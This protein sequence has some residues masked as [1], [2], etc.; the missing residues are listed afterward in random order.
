MGWVEG[1]MRLAGPWRVQAGP[2]TISEVFWP[3]VLLPGLTFAVLY[4]WPFLDQWWTRDRAAHHVLERPR[5][6]PKRTALGVGVL[7]FYVVLFVAGSQDVVAQKTG[8]ALDT[9]L[10]SLRILVF[11]VPAVAAVVAYRLCRDLRAG[12][13][14]PYS[15]D[16]RVNPGIVTP[17]AA[18]D[19]RWAR[20]APRD[21]PGAPRAGPTM[22][23]GA[24]KTIAAVVLA[25]AIVSA[26]RRRSLHHHR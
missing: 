21:A 2:V 19:A 10:T 4:S 14:P 7:A 1:A 22:S 24:A 13:G 20:S 23:P 6:R 18:E 9:V 5:D 12:S 3:A 11:V 26:L 25:G 16:P 17:V 8:L 15:A